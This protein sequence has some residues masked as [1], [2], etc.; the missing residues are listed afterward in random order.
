MNSGMTAKGYAEESRCLHRRRGMVQE[1]GRKGKLVAQEGKGD[2][3]QMEDI[4]KKDTGGVFIAYPSRPDI[5]MLKLS[6]IS[7]FQCMM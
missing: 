7:V 2:P 5:L 1:G 4:Q 6:G 3:L